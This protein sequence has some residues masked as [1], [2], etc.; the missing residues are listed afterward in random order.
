ME[1]SL[2]AMKQKILEELDEYFETTS[3]EKIEE[4]YLKTNELS[5]TNTEEIENNKMNESL[6]ILLENMFSADFNA[7]DF[8]FL[9]TAQSVSITNRDIEWVLQHIEKF[10]Q[11]GLNACLAYIQN[12]KPLEIYL[13]KNFYSALDELIQ[14]KQRVIGDIDYNFYYYNVDGPYRKIN[15]N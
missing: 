3:K 1:Q 5:D 14:R 7:N 12:Q 2:D 9:S 15:I 8:F 10:G 4:L 6:S 11:D 13:T